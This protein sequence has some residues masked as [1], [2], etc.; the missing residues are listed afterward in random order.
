MLQ[1]R[2]ASSDAFQNGSQGQQHQRGSQMP[3]NMYN[4]SMGGIATTNYRGHTSIA[5][6]P[7]A[8]YA[9]SSTPVLPGSSNPLRQH[10]TV[11]H[12]RQENRTTSAPAIPVNQQSSNTL[13]N[14]G[15]YRPQDLSPSTTSSLPGHS[16]DDSV[17]LSQD[18]KQFSSRPLSSIELN[19]SS[20]SANPSMTTPAKPSPDRYRRN[21]RRAETTGLPSTNV[22]SPSGSALPSGSGMATVGHLYSNPAQSS[23]SPSL[24]IYSTYRGTQSPSN[25]NQSAVD[26][27]TIPKQSPTELAKRYR[28]RSI[29]SMDVGDY[30]AEAVDLSSQSPGQTKTYA[31]ML[32]GHPP[33]D[34]KEARPSALQRPSSSHGRK[35]SAESS[36]SG[37]SSSRPSSVRMLWLLA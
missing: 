14:L 18:S 23:S 1:T 33:Q 8:P 24:S 28:R 6:V 27:M 15:R 35:D 22:S 34:R 20:L 13:S 9:F 25:H 3:R 11:P 31:A 26:D 32:A 10:P 21:H 2:P 37:R 17:I 5:S 12:L 36:I 30:K 7:V 19:T 29:S 4:T 16:K